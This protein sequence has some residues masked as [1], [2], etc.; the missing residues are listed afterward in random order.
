MTFWSEVLNY[1]FVLM[2][3]ITLGID[4]FAVSFAGGAYYGKAD[5]RQKFR[6]SFHFGLFQ[7]LMP[8]IGWLAGA[9]IVDI[10]A[11]YDHWI[12]FGLLALIGGNMIR[13]SFSDEEKIRKDISKGFSLISLSVATSIDALAVGFSL[14]IVGDKIII[15]AI[16]IGIVAAIMSLAGIKLGEISNKKFG[17]RISVVG[18]IIL[19][20]I[21]ISIL[22]EHL[23]LY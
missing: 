16:I 14:G 13:D 8:I 21:G 17:G 1:F 4:A 9:S 15:P 11:D 18:G 3:A 6:L 12:A 20:L 2:I 10:V 23:E 22:A 19:I 7:F 5:K